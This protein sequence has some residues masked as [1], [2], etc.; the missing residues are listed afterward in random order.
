MTG[1][2]FTPNVDY[3][4]LEAALRYNVKPSPEAMNVLR[5]LP[6]PDGLSA[7][8]LVT[9]G[10]NY[11]DAARI[12][13]HLRRIGFDDAAARHVLSKVAR[14]I[15]WDSLD[16]IQNEMRLSL[17]S[18]GMKRVPFVGD[19][20]KVIHRDLTVHRYLHHVRYWE[21]WEAGTLWSSYAP[22]FE[23]FLTE[24]RREREL[25]DPKMVDQV[26]RRLTPYFVDHPISV[27]DPLRMVGIPSELW[28]A[29]WVGALVYLGRRHI[30]LVIL[31]V[32]PVVANYVLSLSVPIG[33]PRY[34]YPLMPMYT[35]G[36]V[37][38]LGDSWRLLRHRLDRNP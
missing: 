27:R 26:E 14:A 25:Y 19:P 18:I 9:N 30:G 5:A 34:A 23:R 8:D 4:S 20:D 33:N 3:I 32:S 13:A 24:F 15:K 31:L 7:D 37:I 16:V 17:L 21:K 38:F 10:M 2:G 6:L 35:I 28:I 1:H 22:E 29:G 12:G 36:S 11:S